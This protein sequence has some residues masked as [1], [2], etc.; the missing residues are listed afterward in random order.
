MTR[1]LTRPRT[2]ILRRQPIREQLALGKSRV[3][4]EKGIIF[5]VKVLG[6]TS[7]NTHGV[8]GVE[9][10][11]YTRQAIAD[12]VALCEGIGVNVDHAPRSNPN[13]DRSAR[14][15]FAWLENL[16]ESNDGSHG[17]LHFLDPKDPLAVK[18]MNAAEVKPD[19]FALSINAFGKGKVVG[20]R[21]VIESIPEF[22]SV[23]LVSYG[24]T[25]KSLFESQESKTMKTVK[26]AL[27]E[28]KLKKSS[29]KAIQEMDGMAGCYGKDVEDADPAPPDEAEESYETHLGSAIVA[30]LN[31]DTLDPDAK[32]KKILGVLKVV[33]EEED[34]EPTEESD[35]DQE[36]TE[37]TEE[38]DEEDDEKPETQES[39]AMRELHALKKELALSKLCESE[40]FKPTA[41]Q[42]KI[43]LKLSTKEQTQFIKE[44]R[45]KP[46]V[47]P[48]SGYN[49]LTESAAPK[50]HKEYAAGL[51]R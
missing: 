27:A 42:R 10:T 49:L 41:L 5:G 46:R 4:R 39:R 30:I 29:L 37:R 17:D 38:D 12:S 15:K 2:A 23:D 6:T 48:R 13:L 24:G 31:D 21:Y 43:L 28:L 26:E 45:A 16:T 22:Q 44:N 47:A 33:G 19:A 40:S 36:P 18:V 25:N 3:D 20:K 14:D 32:K 35:E 7:T 11:D 51:L 50:D 9:G 8:R 34:T 1:M